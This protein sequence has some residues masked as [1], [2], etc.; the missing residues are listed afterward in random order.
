MR[1]LSLKVMLSVVFVCCIVLGSSVFGLTAVFGKG[2]ETTLEANVIPG[3][4]K[5]DAVGYGFFGLELVGQHFPGPDYYINNITAL[6]ALAKEVYPS[7]NIDSTNPDSDFSLDASGQDF[8]GYEEH[9]DAGDESTYT[10][11][12]ATE[13]LHNYLFGLA[14]GSTKVQLYF[15][16]TNKAGDMI[17]PIAI[18]GPISLN[19]FMEH[20][21]QLRHTGVGGMLSPSMMGAFIKVKVE[22]VGPNGEA[23]KVSVGVM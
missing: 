16:G 17:D 10:D 6:L 20:K 11:P 1:K 12:G 23:V 2:D 21:I 18:G 22:Q 19:S 9:G 5:V 4:F 14:D 15:F 8:S 7:S 3:L 13:V